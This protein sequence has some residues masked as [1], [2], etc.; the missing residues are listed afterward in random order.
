[1]S[2]KSPP[3]DSQTPMQYHEKKKE[4]KEA[5]LFSSVVELYSPSTTLL[6]MVDL[7]TRKKKKHTHKRNV[8]KK[9]ARN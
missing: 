1:M 7:R 4:G 3:A 9:G 6:K 2:L 8:K 5:L